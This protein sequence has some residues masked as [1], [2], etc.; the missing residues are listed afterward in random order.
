MGWC[1]LV[2]LIWYVLNARNLS[3]HIH[4]LEIC[5]VYAQHAIRNQVIAKIA[6]RKV[7]LNR[8]RNEFKYKG[9]LRA[10]ISILKLLV[11][12]LNS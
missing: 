10:F 12:S 6:E 4:D 7:I 8:G 2:S 1:D 3:P 11:F 9:Q 5:T